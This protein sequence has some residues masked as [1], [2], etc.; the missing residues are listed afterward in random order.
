MKDLNMSLS[1]YQASIPLLARMLN[2][3]SGIL[4]KAASHAAN[5]K[6]DESIF[7]NARLTPDMFH[8]ARQI[9]VASDT[10]KGCAARLSGIDVPS[11]ADTETTFAELQERLSK[12]I[13]FLES[14]TSTQVDGSEQR[15]ITLSFPNATL[16]FTGQDYLLKFVLPNF[17]FHISMAYAILRHHGV[18][19][20]KMDFLGKTD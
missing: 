8:L 2:N 1:M 16:E 18:D 5:K 14:I 12:T 19:I 15:S 17:F 10:A 4:T 7:I 11:Y 9:Q 13:Q 20:G 3:L 6:I